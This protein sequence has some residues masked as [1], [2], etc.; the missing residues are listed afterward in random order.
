MRTR[1]RQRQ[2]RHLTDGRL[3]RFWLTGWVGLAA[4]AFANGTLRA[5]VYQD[6]V[7]ETAARQIATGVLLVVIGIY[8]TVLHHRRPLPDTPTALAV[9]AAWAAMTL[10]FE[11]GVGHYVLG[12]PWQTLLADYDLTQGR[13]WV[14]VP[15]ATLLA[16]ALV[17]SQQQ[18]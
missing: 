5:M 9:G 14:L 16:P 10:A 18:R 17:R 8:V 15:I 6:L 2:L 7:G 1:L 13:L 3:W 4:L 11:F 12:T